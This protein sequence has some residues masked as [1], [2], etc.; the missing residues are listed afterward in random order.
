ML[1]GSLSVCLFA[2]LFTC[3]TSSG[4]HILKSSFYMCRITFM[5]I[6]VVIL[7]TNVRK[8][9]KIYQAFTDASSDGSE[10]KESA[11]NAETWVRSLAGRALEKGN[12][13]L[14]WLS[15]NPITEPGTAWSPKELDTMEWRLNYRGQ[16]FCIYY[17]LYYPHLKYK[18]TEIWEAG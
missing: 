15:G 8:G 7:N 11:H 2:C 9:T 18:K 16:W 17:I 4:G 14:Q 10:A 1:H 6:S 3:L 12:D 13:N 5:P